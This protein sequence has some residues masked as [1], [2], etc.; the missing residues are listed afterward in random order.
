MEIS[1]R[2]IKKWSSIGARPT[3]G[4]TLMELAEKN[5]NLMVLTA[6][7][8]TSAGLERYKRTYPEQ[9]LDV[10]IAEQNMMGI[11]SGLAKE[12][13]QVVTTTF[14]PFQT[15]RCLEQI[16]VNQG[17][18]KLPVVMVGLASGIYHSYLGN[19]HCCFEDAAIMR[20]IPNLSVVTPADGAEIV[21]S[22]V[23]ATEYGK[24][25]YIRLIERKGLPIVYQGDFEFSIGKANVLREGD[26]IAILANGTMASHALLVADSLMECGIACRV[27]DFHTVKPLD[28][29]MLDSLEEYKLI[30]TIEE[31]SV[32]GGLGSA[33]AEYMMQKR[34]KPL[35]KLFG[36]QDFYP[37]AGEYEQALRQ[38]GLMPEQMA[39][40]IRKEIGEL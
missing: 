4:L 3:L 27:V 33:V 28:A 32:I 30:V 38:C 24:P 13:Y 14:A 25:V 20:A 7:V 18:M 5:E 22:V 34:K 19:T 8:S 1:S 12:G 29:A 17:Y 39:E 11:A 6:D 26:D 16:R 40:K 36:I 37:H 23:A 21:K 35:L 31:H 10:G 15:M 9:F 2:N